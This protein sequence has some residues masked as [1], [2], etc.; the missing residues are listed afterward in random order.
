MRVDLQNQIRCVGHMRVHMPRAADI[1]G[2]S[3]TR[4]VTAAPPIEGKSFGFI[5]NGSSAASPAARAG[6]TAPVPYRFSHARNRPGRGSIQPTGRAG[7]MSDNAT[8][9]DEDERIRLWREERA[10]VAEAEK[11][12]LDSIGWARYGFGPDWA[13]R[14]KMR[15]IAS[16]SPRKG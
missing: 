6:G 2:R 12:R 14:A 1:E 3:D 8:D 4:R 15:E 7:V 9:P 5:A 10:R 11:V 13:V 16:L